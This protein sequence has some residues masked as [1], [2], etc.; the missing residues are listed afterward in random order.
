MNQFKQEELI[1]KNGKTY[2]V[3][4]G[5]LRLCH[6]DN[7]K[8][9]IQTKIIE[10]SHLE[11]AI[12]EATI[13]TSTG[14]FKAHGVAS[15]EKDHKLVTSLLELAETRAIA[16]GLRFAGYGVEYT[17]VE[18]MPVESTVTQQSDYSGQVQAQAQAQPQAHDPITRPQKHAIE[19]IAAVHGWGP[20]NCAK[21]ILEWHDL[22][23]LSEISKSQASFVIQKM[24]EFKNVA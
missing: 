4:G 2:P 17:G 19:T 21:R 1:E 22:A 6:E 20:L 12:V 9:E 15:K 24:K 16:R 13:T 8:L 14:I 5:R 11:I 10:F 23:D 3:V 7:E 18:E